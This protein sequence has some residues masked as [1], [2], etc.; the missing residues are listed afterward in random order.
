[1]SD[2]FQPLMEAVARK[3]LG[4]PNPHLSTPGQELRFG[5]QG[6]MSIDLV[7]GTFFNHEAGSG[8]GVAELIAQYAPGGNV[9]DILEQEFGVPKEQRQTL[10]TLP[11]T[12]KATSVTPYDYVDDQGEVRYQVIRRTMSDGSKQFRQSRPGPD[13]RPVY[14]LKGVAPLPYNLPRILKT[15][16]ALFIAE[17]EKCVDALTAAGLLA[18]TNSGG[19]KNWK[20]ELNHWFQGRSVVIIPDNDAPGEA[21]ARHVAEQLQGVADEIRILRLPDLPP[22]GDVADWLVLGGDRKRLVELASAAEAWTPEQAPAPEPVLITPDEPGKYFEL[23]AFDDLPEVEIRW[24]VK[25]LLPAQ[26]FH[27]LFGQS[28]SYKSFVAM[29]LSTMI[30][31]GQQAFGKDV[32]QGSVVYL[33]G[34]GKSGLRARRDALAKQFNLAPRT[35]IF[36]LSDQ[37]DLRSTPADAEKLV[38]SV[39]R[40]GIQPVMVVIDTLNR[41]FSGGNENNS[42]DMGNFIRLTGWIQSRLNTAVMIVHHSG[43]DESKGARGHSSLRAALDA[44]IEVTRLSDLGDDNR[45]G[46][47]T[48]T[49]QKDGEDGE[50][51]HYELALIE[52]KPGN[53]VNGDGAVSSLVVVPKEPPARPERQAKKLTK[54]ERECLDALKAAIGEAGESVGLQAIPVGAKVVRIELARQYFYQTCV[55]DKASAKAAFNRGMR[56]LK[57]SRSV[58]CHDPYLWL[59]ETG[60]DRSSQEAGRSKPEQ[61]RSQ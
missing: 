42:D 59:I 57:A 13:G 53:P 24:L 8:G 31:S 44:E 60:A 19:A 61:S 3:Y 40:L 5:R 32:A 29:Y 39:E 51:I 10:L 7:K 25:D 45:R 30:A 28:G 22:K 34:E 2:K 46:M 50:T 37:L 14:D 6:S 26:G 27:N 9:V 38:S 18:T 11:Q 35:P 36:F 41:A 43:K 54:D 4:D 21:H 16:G 56:N 15:S 47:M 1:M 48:V 49:K 20:P 55:L 23:I 17:G 33:A 12:P 52:T 58:G